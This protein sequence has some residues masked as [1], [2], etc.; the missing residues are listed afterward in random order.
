MS[1]ILF[2]YSALW[3]ASRFLTV[4]RST[5]VVLK[6]QTKIS[7]IVEQISSPTHPA[8]LGA[9]GMYIMYYDC[10]ELYMNDDDDWLYYWL[11]NLYMFPWIK[12]RSELFVDCLCWFFKT[13]HH[14][15][16]CYYNHHMTYKWYFGFDVIYY[17]DFCE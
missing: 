7:N 12:I 3:Q 8:V 6:N 16:S 17:N 10:F 5:C 9:F 15:L 4:K 13:P 11:L 1:F 2:G 14:H